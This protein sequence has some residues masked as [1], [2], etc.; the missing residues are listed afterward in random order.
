MRARVERFEWLLFFLLLQ[1]FCIASTAI[2]SMNI[3]TTSN[4][5]FFKLT[6]L[7]CWSEEWTVN[8]IHI[9]NSHLFYLQI[10]NLNKSMHTV[11]IN[12]KT[13]RTEI[14]YIFICF[15]N[16]KKKASLNRRPSGTTERINHNAL[17][18]P[19]DPLNL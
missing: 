3:S 13:S 15:M 2:V 5:T 8:A 7:P 18:T 11:D 14:A 16:K 19:T 17:H 4:L 6:K 9:F 10:K 12:V 1:H